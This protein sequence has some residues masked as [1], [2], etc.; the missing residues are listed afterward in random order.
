MVLP[1]QQFLGLSS[2]HFSH[3]VLPVQPYV[4]LSFECPFIL[5]ILLTKELVYSENCLQQG[6]FAEIF[7]GSLSEGSYYITGDEWGM[8]KRPKYEWPAGKQI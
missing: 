8:K 2:A 7:L 5:S 4:F 6:A 1:L 3:K